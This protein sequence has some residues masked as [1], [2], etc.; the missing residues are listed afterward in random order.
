M[1]RGRQMADWWHTAN[2]LALLANVNRTKRQR[3]FT[4]SDFHPLVERERRRTNGMRI[5]KGNISA[6]KVFLKHGASP[7]TDNEISRG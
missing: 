4:P 5:T 3:A 2:I 7:H 6:L 1:V